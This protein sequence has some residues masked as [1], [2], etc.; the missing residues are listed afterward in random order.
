MAHG[1]ERPLAMAHAQCRMATRMAHGM[2]CRETWHGA[3]S[4]T[5]D[6]H[7]TRYEGRRIPL[8][9]HRGAPQ[10][11]ALLR[12]LCGEVGSVPRATT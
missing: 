5:H 2:A 9:G 8:Q 11:M 4:H 6:G 7:E 12:G 10:R 3:V 1:N